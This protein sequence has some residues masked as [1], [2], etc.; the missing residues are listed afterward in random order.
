MLN[1]L[2]ALA[3]KKHI[4]FAKTEKIIKMYWLLSISIAVIGILFFVTQQIRLT[5]HPQLEPNEFKYSQNIVLQKKKAVIEVD[6]YRGN[7]KR[8]LNSKRLAS[9]VQ[10]S[11][12]S[13]DI[14]KSSDQNI[15]ESLSRVS[16]VT[17]QEADNEGTRIRVRGTNQRDDV[18]LISVT[19]YKGSTVQRYNN[20]A[21]VQAGSGI[22]NWRWNSYRI[23]WQSPVAN[24]QPFSMIILSGT[25]TRIL[26]IISVFLGLFWLYL[27]FKNTTNTLLNKFKSN[28]VLPSIVACVVC[29]SIMPD[30]NAGNFPNSALLDELKQRIYQAPTCAPA[31]AVINKLDIVMQQQSLHLAFSIHANT[32][33]A[34]AL[35]QSEFWQPQQ[36]QINNKTVQGL[37]KHNG[38]VYLAIPKG[39]HTIDMR[40]KLATVE[41]FQLRFNEQPKS[42]TFNDNAFWNVAGLDKNTL[43][44]NRLEFLAK[45]SVVKAKSRSSQSVISQ[46]R[47]KPFVRVIRDISLGQQ[48]EVNTEIERV[49]PALGAINITIDLLPGE[50][51][52]SNNVKVENRQVHVT[53]PAGKNYF[54]WESTI[55]RQDIITL[56]A[57]AQPDYFE[58]W[59]VQSS[60]E[61]HSELSGFPAVLNS[62][63]RNASIQHFYPY[64]NEVL[65]IKSHRP[66][67]IKGD[68]IAIDAVNYDIE[69]GTRTTKLALSFNYRS[70]RGGNH[71]IE[72]P[73]NFQVK[74]VKADNQH[75]KLQ[76]ENNK[77]SIPLKPGT[78]SINIELRSNE[79][80]QMVFNSPSIN[81]N[82]SISNINTRVNVNNQRWILGTQGPL[83]GPAILYWGELLIF[84]LLALIISRVPFSPLSTLSWIIL[85]LGLSLNN[86]GV[87][88]LIASWFA[89]LTA[90]SYRSQSMST[91]A[92]NFS[93]VSLYALSIIT[94]LAIVAVIPL[95][96]LSSPDMGITGNSSHQHS[97]NWFADN[98]QGILP[99]ITIVSVPS[100]IYKGVMLVWVIWLSFTL[101]N[102]IKWAWKKL[103]E[104]GYW[105]AKVT[106]KESSAE[107]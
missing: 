67:A 47:I 71:I 104:N 55:E 10:D 54:D 36:W 64:P 62:D 9:G 23:N 99:S 76:P 27:I 18:E 28:T 19:G 51:V 86:W 39:I 84:I 85:G 50:Y 45:E 52:T 12:Y 94:I 97:L 40:G 73:E 32:P 6:G 93:Q 87:L 77:L 66:K 29:T 21:M 41:T 98:A 82:A 100:L 74:S 49:A 25:V 63:Y 65:T 42:V 95:S 46:H 59:H 70:T 5:V 105:R 3:L 30:A 37:V 78:H 11:I 44:S 96:L 101:L 43:T 35:P 31:C 83:V 13:E 89:A 60:A 26:N 79:V 24:E 22:P 61:W 75:I 103:G 14:G 88:I 90:A 91:R 68:M 107:S 2:V 33:T 34:V 16:G 106:V 58:Q 80:N 53:I 17:V 1:L 8:N 92:Y 56:T 48:W 4:T 57:K 69:Q 20:D 38:W 15:A 7:L 81:L 102:W 72:L